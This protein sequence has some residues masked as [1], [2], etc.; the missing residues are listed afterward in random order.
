MPDL[1]MILPWA[2][3]L[4]NDGVPGITDKTAEGVW[5]LAPGRVMSYHADIQAYR[6]RP[7]RR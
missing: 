6:S 5:R 2:V 7:R 4:E 1:S 3:R